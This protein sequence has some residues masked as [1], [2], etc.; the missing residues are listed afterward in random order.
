[1]FVE[2]CISKEFSELSGR[3]SVLGSKNQIVVGLNDYQMAE[4]SESIVVSEDTHGSIVGHIDMGESHA[5]FSYET[6]LSGQAVDLV[7]DLDAAQVKR[8]TLHVPAGYK[9]NEQGCLEP[10]VKRAYSE[11]IEKMEEVLKSKG[12]GSKCVLS[13]LKE[14]GVTNGNKR[15]FSN[16]NTF[17]ANK[18]FKCQ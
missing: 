5:V 13:L 16:G 2:S 18:T 9:E 7:G 12:I 14:K 1:M 6:K 4:K 11:K 10:C 15:V 3:F 8:V 17:V